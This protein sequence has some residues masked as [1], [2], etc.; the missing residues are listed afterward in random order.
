MGGKGLPRGYLFRP[1]LTAE[2]FL[3]NP[4]S[5]HAGARLYRTG[6]LARYLPDGNIEFLGRIDSQVKI[7]GLR[8]ELGEIEAVLAQHPG[9]ETCAAVVREDKPGQKQLVAY[10]VAPMQDHTFARKLREDLQGKLPYFMVPSRYVVM[11]RLPVTSNGKLDR[12]ALPA[13]S[14]SLLDSAYV[15]PQTCTEKLLV[16]IWADL[17]DVAQV[18]VEDNFFEL[19]G[20]SLLAT[21][22]VSRLRTVLELEFSVRDVFESPT[23]ARLAQRVEV[24]SA[25]AYGQIPFQRLSIPRDQELPLSFAQQRLWFLDQLEPDS[26]LYSVPAA[27]RVEGTLDVDALE[28]SLHAVVQRHEVLRTVFTALEGKPLQVV[29]EHSNLVFE[30]VDLREWGEGEAGAE[31]EARRR[32]VAEA[33]RPFQLSQGPL[34][35]AMLLRVSASESVLLLNLHHIVSDGW[36]LGVLIREMGL[37]YE[38][39]VEGRVSPLAELQYQYVDFAQWQRQWLQ[40]EALERQLGYWKQQLEGSPTV[41]ELP[42]DRPR[43]AVQSFAG[44]TEMFELPWELSE[45]VKELSQRRG[46]TLFMTL[47]GAY[48]VL[49]GRYSGQ[50]DVVVGSPIANRNRS[51]IEGLIGLFVN[52]LVLRT[53]MKDNPSVGEMLKRV[54]EVA[55][56]GYAHQDVPFEKLVEE[57]HPQRQ[58]SHSPLFQVMFVLQNAPLPTLK[59]KGLTT[60]PVPLDSGDGQVRLDHVPDGR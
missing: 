42:T 27:I 14:D 3:P 18:G 34:L 40:G 11:G 30:Q 36:S 15:A 8:I 10:I 24:A 38:A 12:K 37:L 13:P 59:L 47:L 7:R 21:Q 4:F 16:D 20:H 26:P 51:E 33:R 53:E 5:S 9:V 58:M 23:P 54:Q 31:E 57:L 49:L 44:G 39:M 29:L 28:R 35:R 43:P 19:G 48:Q 50:M 41:L 25:R 22:L 55:L 6:D 45:K 32:M 1:E 2:K 60:T 56:E 17:L 52:T 46:M